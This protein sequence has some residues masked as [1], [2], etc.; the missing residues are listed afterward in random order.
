MKI[1]APHDWDVTP[2]EARQIQDELRSS[3]VAEGHPVGVK[4]VAGTDISVGGSGR[5]GLAAVVVVEYPS[6][7]PVEQSVVEALVRFPYLPGLLSFRETPLLAPAFE[8]L[9]CTPDLVIVDGQGQAHPRRFGIASHIGLLL[10]VPTIGCA[11]S[12]LIGQYSE[13]AEERGSCTPLYDHGEV[14]GEVVRTRRGVKPLFVSVGHCIALHATTEWILR[15]TMG[16]RLPEPTR[17]AHL[18]AAGIDVVGRTT[19]GQPR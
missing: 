13:P 11:K 6:L 1:T 16:L 10:G 12:R 18:A 9:Q 5:P 19:G 7:R 3:I 2:A 17:L 8:R 4:L 14:I 15:L